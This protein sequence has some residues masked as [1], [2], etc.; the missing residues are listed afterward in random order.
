MRIMTMVKFEVA[1]PAQ[2]QRL[3]M[4]QPDAPRARQHQ[5]ARH[6]RKRLAS[7]VNRRHQTAGQVRAEPYPQPCPRPDPPRLKVS[8]PRARQH[9]IAR[10]DHQR[11]ASWVNRRHQTAG[12]VRAEP[13]PQPYPRHDPWP[14]T[15]H[16]DN[17]DGA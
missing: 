3:S 5:I 17:F 9:Q 1:L 13:Y 11:L 15:E 4:R 16:A 12:Q 7:W 8:A 14:K 10:H 2:L 6:D